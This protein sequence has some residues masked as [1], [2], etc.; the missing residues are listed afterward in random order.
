MAVKLGR[1]AEREAKRQSPENMDGSVRRLDPRQMGTCIF[2]V[3]TYAANVLTHRPRGTHT[4][5][6]R[7]VVSRPKLTEQNYVER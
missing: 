4:C 3:D 1:W 5:R 7:K 6:V 2:I